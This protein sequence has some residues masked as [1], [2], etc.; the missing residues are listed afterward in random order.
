M[1]SML[2][3]DRFTPS[4]DVT[5]L[6]SVPLGFPGPMIYSE[7]SYCQTHFKK[8]MSLLSLGDLTSCIVKIIC[9]AVVCFAA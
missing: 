6:I 4:A 1:V 2:F 3:P 9:E 7:I 5:H 8:S